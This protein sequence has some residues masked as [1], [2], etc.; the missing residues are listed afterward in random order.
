[1]EER[2]VLQRLHAWKD[3]PREPSADC[4]EAA[5]RIHHR[6]HSSLG[7]ANQ[8]TSQWCLPKKNWERV[9]RTWSTGT[10]RTRLN[11]TQED[12][13]RVWGTRTV[14]L[15][16]AV[17]AENASRGRE[18]ASAADCPITSVKTARKKHKDQNATNA[19]S[20]DMLRLNALNNRK[21]R[22]LSM[23]ELLVKNT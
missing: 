17:R 8:H 7:I 2:W 21:P 4:R 3:H 5:A 15:E 12:T 1:M 19:V 16:R 10:G 9:L 14:K 22:A 20:M 6:Q 18:T 23:R 11:V 13:S